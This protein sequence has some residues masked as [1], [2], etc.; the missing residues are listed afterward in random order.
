MIVDMS[1]AVILQDVAIV[2]TQQA[3]VP[4]LDCIPKV[5]GD[6]TKEGIQSRA[7]LLARHPVALEL[8][9]EWPG[10]QFELRVSVG[11]QHE[12][13]K[14]LRIEKPRIRLSCLRAVLSCCRFN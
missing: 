13:M 3:R 8:K 5:F 4:D 12:V 7:E 11:S 2:R 6:L 1:D 9:Q 10:V 14:E